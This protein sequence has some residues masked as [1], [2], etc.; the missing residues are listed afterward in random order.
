MKVWDFKGNYVR[1]FGQDSESTYFI[2]I[3]FGLIVMVPSVSM[4]LKFIIPELEILFAEFITIFISGIGL[5]DFVFIT[6]WLLV[7]M[8]S[9]K[10]VSS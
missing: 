2:D 4:K 8:M 3:F 5:F 7:T 10:N 6:K 1:N 9:P